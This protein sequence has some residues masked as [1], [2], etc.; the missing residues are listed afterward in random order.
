MRRQYGQARA[1]PE[2]AGQ[3]QGASTTSRRWLTTLPI[4]PARETVART[5]ARRTPGREGRHARCRDAAANAPAAALEVLAG[6]RRAGNRGRRVL[7]GRRV[8]RQAN[9]GAVPRL[10]SSPRLPRQRLH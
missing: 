7:A 3:T 9:R 2:E 1:A 8:D 4:S 6:A 5:L 10:P